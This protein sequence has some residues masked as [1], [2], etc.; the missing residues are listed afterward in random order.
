MQLCNDVPSVDEARELL[1]TGDSFDVDARLSTSYGARFCFPSS[2][3]S[4]D[5]VQQENDDPEADNIRMLNPCLS[6][7][8]Y[9]LGD[10]KVEIDLPLRADLNKKETVLGIVKGALDLR[11]RALQAADEEDITA[12]NT[13]ERPLM[14]DLG[15]TIAGD[16]SPSYTF[17]TLKAGNPDGFKNIH[18]F[19]G[20]FHWDLNM[21][22]RHGFRFG[23]SHLKYFL[24]P[25]R[26][27]D[28]KKDWYLNPG[29]PNQTSL[30][31]PEMTD[32]HYVT[33]MRGL[34][35][36][37]K[38]DPISA[39]DVDDW[40]LERALDHDLCMTVL[41]DL[42]FAEVNYMIRDSEREGKKGNLELF[43]IGAKLS[44]LLFART[45]AT[46][47][48]R[49]AVEYWIWWRCSS[50]ADKKLY[51]EFYYT[52][53]TVNGTP[54]WVDRFVEWMNKDLREYLGKYAKPN[55]ELLLRRAS[56]L[57]K[58]RK[59]DRTELNRLFGI[60]ER[61]ELGANREEKKLAISVIFCHQLDL[62]DKLNLWGDGAVKVGKGNCFEEPRQFTDP[63]GEH[64]LNT[65]SLFDISGAEE[66]IMAYFDFNSLSG[67]L[68]QVGRSEKDVSL[69]MTPVLLAEVEQ[70]RKDEL[71]RRTSHNRDLLGSLTT[72]AYLTSRLTE[73]REEF[74]FLCTEVTEVQIPNSS[75][76][77]DKFV[78]A[79]AKAHENIIAEV[80]DFVRQ[81]KEAMSAQYLL[82]NGFADRQRKRRELAR[83]FYSLPQTAK[84][85]FFDRKYSILYIE[86]VEERREQDGDMQGDD[87]QPARTP[88]RAPATEEE[89]SDTPFLIREC[90]RMSLFTP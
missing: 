80:P 24:H 27:T 59:R 50:D 28:K 31:Q 1:S 64:E 85:E 20:G 37:K 30:E 2:Q 23:D 62:I 11:D 68:N 67:E 29:D 47:Y 74:P 90:D 33:A 86:D 71:N 53:Q 6:S 15:I 32:A 76:K 13:D 56:L 42:R 89:T 83:P 81:V 17:L 39:V 70:S 22:Q 26:D 49:M 75:E 9:N 82:C 73:L 7:T 35:K 45:H 5:V 8:M 65:E 34:S 52:K 36:L 51:Q 19:C 40:M 63:S 79:V 21:K 58:D 61:G 78:E 16:G 44:L 72:K 84:A 12:I 88:E 18:N 25:F 54:I 48:V 77:K 43:R 57:L 46:K 66:A 4:V 55:Q 3:P 87:E 60:T 41:M 69:R 10:Q 38:G 14:E